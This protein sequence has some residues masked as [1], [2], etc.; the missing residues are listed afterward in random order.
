MNRA[1]VNF[2]KLQISSNNFFKKCGHFDEKARTNLE[3][4]TK[5]T[6]NGFVGNIVAF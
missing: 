6:N 5:K 1:L 3:A 4:D 2:A